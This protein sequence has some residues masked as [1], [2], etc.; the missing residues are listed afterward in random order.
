MLKS[1]QNAIDQSIKEKQPVHLATEMMLSHA[2]RVLCAHWVGN[3]K[4][5]PHSESR[6]AVEIVG[7][8]DNGNEDSPDWTVILHEI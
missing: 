7:W 6:N 1:Y 2:E 3:T 4:V 5:Y 8:S